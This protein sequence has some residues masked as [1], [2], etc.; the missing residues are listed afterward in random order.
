MV[1]QF[2]AHRSPSKSRV[3]ALV[4]SGEDR[5]EAVTTLGAADAD[6]TDALV[7]ALNSY[8]AERDEKP[9]QAVLDRMPDAV[10][11]AVRN[12]VGERCT[13]ELGAFTGYGPV[14]DIRLCYFSQADEEFIQY[15]DAA[16]V[17][18]LGIRASNEVES[19]GTVSWEVQL[20]SDEVFVPAGAEPRTWTLPQAPLLRTWTSEEAV[21]DPVVSAVAVARKASDDGHWVRLHTL[22]KGD[23]EVEMD[24]TSTSTFVVD[25]LDAPIPRSA[26]DE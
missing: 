13:F 12:F 16:Y 8:L 5:L 23:G 4:R 26:H 6:A 1:Y 14:D 21:R 11:I 19:A 15:L 17:I 2:L 9:L 7:S 22:A 3:F 18:G 10:R 20:L 24:S 25:V